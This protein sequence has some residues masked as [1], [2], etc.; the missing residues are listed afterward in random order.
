MHAYSNLPVKCVCNGCECFR[1]VGQP[2]E[3]WSENELHLHKKSYDRGVIPWV[4]SMWVVCDQLCLVE[5]C[6]YTSDQSLY[7]YRY[8]LQSSPVFGPVHLQGIVNA[9]WLQ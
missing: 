7:V 1:D 5:V 8:K 4:V 2:L 6:F 9:F 3:A